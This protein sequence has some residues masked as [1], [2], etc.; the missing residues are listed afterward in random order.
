MTMGIVCLFGWLVSQH[1][2]QQLGYIAD[3]SK[4]WRLTTIYVLPH[5]RQSW[6]T[7]TSVS[8]RHIILTPTPPAGGGRPQRK[9]NPGPPH[10]ESHALPTE[11][12][13]SQQRGWHRHSMKQVWQKC[14]KRHRRPMKQVWQKCSKR[15]R[16]P[17]KQVWQ[18]CSKRHR[19][20]M[21]QVW[22]ECSN[23]HRRPMK[24]V[25]QK[26]SK[27]HRRPM[28][29]VWQKCSKRHRSPWSKSGRNAQRDADAPWSKSG[30]NAQSDKGRRDMKGHYWWCF[31]TWQITWWTVTSHW[32]WNCQHKNSI[33]TPALT[34]SYCSTG[35]LINSWPK[36][37]LSSDVLYVIGD[38]ECYGGTTAEGTTVAK[39][40]SDVL[41]VIVDT[42]S[43]TQTKAIFRC[44]LCDWRLWKS[45]SNQSYIQ[46][47]FMWLEILKVW[48]KPKLYSDVLY[49]IGDCE[50]FG[51]GCEHYSRG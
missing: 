13:R 37:K 5:T 35:E 14:S 26:C 18:K 33:L 50:C 29:Q 7:I 16:R 46:M 38:T 6:E 30:R 4:D 1:P 51:G 19:R 28:K 23:R 11:L 32:Q 31:K 21:K 8:A 9:S 34:F 45:D 43:V 47:F 27:R 17:M 15:H 3:R 41:Y 42:E 40:N 39:T 12:S 10:Q 36:P 24:Q 44:S 48:P 20:P 2:H 25:W 49:V 22:Q